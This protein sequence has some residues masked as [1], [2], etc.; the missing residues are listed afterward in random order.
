M[1]QPIGTP[2]SPG[3][4]I[5]KDSDSFRVLISSRSLPQLSLSGVYY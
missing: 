3:E 2:K 1:R 5:V 4:K